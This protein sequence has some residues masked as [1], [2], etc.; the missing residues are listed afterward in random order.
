MRDVGSPV[1]QASFVAA[2]GAR[3][4]RHASRGGAKSRL[5]V[6]ERVH[7][8]QRAFIV[9]GLRFYTPAE[10]RRLRYCRMPGEARRYGR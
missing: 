8:S 9:S 1:S 3:L 2:H 6:V 7:A 4:R 10:A 5:F